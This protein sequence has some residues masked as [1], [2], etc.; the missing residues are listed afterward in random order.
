MYT[1]LRRLLFI[2]WYAYYK[3]KAVN[4][5]IISINSIQQFGLWAAPISRIA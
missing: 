1:N 4:E 3:I 5:M 2:F